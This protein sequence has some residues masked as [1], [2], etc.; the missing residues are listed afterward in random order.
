MHPV[1][2]H[3]SR[4]SRSGQP[5]C[6]RRSSIRPGWVHGTWIHSTWIHG[7][8]R[9]G[10]FVLVVWEHEVKA[11]TVDIEDLAEI[12]ARHGGALDMPAW[13]AASPGRLPERLTRLRAF[14]QREVT[15]VGLSRFTLR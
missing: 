12:L 2:G 10:T 9:L 6:I 11:T 13:T 15:R 14:P 5:G 4:A 7:A 8:D 3:L 1:A